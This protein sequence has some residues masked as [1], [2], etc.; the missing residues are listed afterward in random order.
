MHV[1]TGAEGL[2]AGTGEDDDPYVEVVAAVGERLTHLPHCQRRK[3]IAVARAVDSDLCD[4]V[5]FLKENLLE[6]EPLLLF[7]ILFP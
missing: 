1:A 4:V 5:V 3:R 6:V 7:S 2:V